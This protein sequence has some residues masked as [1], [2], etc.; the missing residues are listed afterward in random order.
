MH[1]EPISSGRKFS[2]W[3]WSWPVLCGVKKENQRRLRAGKFSCIARISRP[4]KKGYTL[5][6]VRDPQFYSSNKTM[7]MRRN[8]TE[9][10]KGSRPNASKKLREIRQKK[11]SCERLENSVLT[12]PETLI[13]TAWFTLTQHM[14]LQRWERRRI[15]PIQRFK[16]NKNSS[17]LLENQWNE[18]VNFQ[19]WSPPAVP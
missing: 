9:E 16:A 10:G 1:R 13:H 19:K 15:C 3:Q 7:Q 12:A 11:L 2:S 14:G 17:G 4:S 18:E 8:Y 6:I 5:S